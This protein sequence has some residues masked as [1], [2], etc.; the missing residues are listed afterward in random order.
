MQTRMADDE[1]D[2]PLLERLLRD[3]RPELHQR[4]A[5]LL[6]AAADEGQLVEQ[7]AALAGEMPPVTGEIGEAR[8][9]NG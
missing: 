1:P 3:P 5:D 8:V 6:W 9:S 2:L 4:L 7:A